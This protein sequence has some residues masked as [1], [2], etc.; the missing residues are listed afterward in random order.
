[1]NFLKKSRQFLIEIFLVSICFSCA[2]ETK[3]KLSRNDVEEIRNLSA[4]VR[5]YL[6]EENKAPIITA[7]Y[8]MYVEK[9]E[10]SQMIRLDFP[11]TDG[12]SPITV[13]SDGQESVII[14]TSTEEVISRNINTSDLDAEQRKINK[15]VKNYNFGRIDKSSFRAA[16]SGYEV[17]YDKT[18]KETSIELSSKYLKNEKEKCLS[19]TVIYDSDTGL[20]KKTE[21]ISEIENGIICTTTS[22]P[23]YQLFDNGNYIKTGLTT[24]IKYKNKSDENH[25]YKMVVREVYSDIKVNQGNGQ[26]FRAIK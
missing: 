23:E 8:K 13:L 17:T 20:L 11:S 12:T 5:V 21:I 14:N 2:N 1:M 6:E 7:D 24:I 3:Q 4:N 9:S 19:T 26:E 10:D 22:S 15:L 18:T 25:S 16:I